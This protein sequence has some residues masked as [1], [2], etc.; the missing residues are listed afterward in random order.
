MW[1]EFK[2]YPL[3]LK[4]KVCDIAQN[5][6]KCEIEERKNINLVIFCTF[7]NPKEREREEKKKC[8]QYLKILGNER[9]GLTLWGV[10]DKRGHYSVC[11]KVYDGNNYF[12]Q[13]KNQRGFYSIGVKENKAAFYR[14]R[15]KMWAAPPYI[16]YL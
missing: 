5:K 9:G 11:G 8:K 14:K 3:T 16:E 10:K 15:T 2:I 4:S 1:I 6:R 13:G 12:Y 7:C